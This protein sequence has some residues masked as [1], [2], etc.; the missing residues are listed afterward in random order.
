[1][2]IKITNDGKEKPM[3]FEASVIDS[4]VS[5][6]MFSGSLTASGFGSSEFEAKENLILCLKKIVERITSETATERS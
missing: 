6:I 3:S 5:E 2:K 4:E 1:V